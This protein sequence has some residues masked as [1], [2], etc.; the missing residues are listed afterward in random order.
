MLEP[1]GFKRSLL[2]QDP[3]TR[4]F[5]ITSNI[6]ENVVKS[7]EHNLWATQR[8][9]EQ[10]L[11]DAFR[12]S[13]AVILVFS[14]NKSGAFQGYA[15][16]RSLIGRATCHKDPFNGFGRL[17]DVEWLRLHDVD[18]AEVNYLRNPLDESRQVGYSRDGQELGHSVGA[19]L[20]RHFDVQ[21]YRED[22]S[23]YEPVTDVRPTLIREP[24]PKPALLALPARPTAA[25]V[26]QQSPYPHAQKPEGCTALAMMPNQA[27]CHGPYMT[28]PPGHFG[29]HGY[30]HQAYGPPPPPWTLPQPHTVYITD[31]YGRRRRGRRRRRRRSS[32]YSYDS[33]RERKDKQK[34]NKRKKSSTEGKSSKQKKEPD[35]LNMSY[36]EYMKWWHKKHSMAPAQAVQPVGSPDADKAVQPVGSPEADKAVQPADNAVQLAGSLEADKAVQPVDSPG[37]DKAHEASAGPGPSAANMEEEA[38]AAD[39]TSR[40]ESLETYMA[41]L[42]AGKMEL[43]AEGA[44]LTKEIEQLNADIELVTAGKHKDGNAADCGASDGSTP[45]AQSDLPEWAPAEDDAKEQVPLGVYQ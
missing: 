26:F 10:K 29:T 34:K 42:K 3:K 9:N 28:P 40:I 20:C 22:P 25:P 15:R 45:S 19:E 16:M 1:K 32:S 11:N 13:T 31:P 39:A 7:V 18:V 21:I 41:D 30:P 37:A 14:V 8:K 27:G 38:F 12:T 43:T 24:S 2:L 5:I 23:S 33:D 6:G 35:F 36:D 44:D 17:F 4:Y